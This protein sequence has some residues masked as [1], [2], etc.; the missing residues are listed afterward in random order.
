MRTGIRLY[1]PLPEELKA[2]QL[3]LHGGA[4]VRRELLPYGHHDITDDDVAAVVRA[5]RSEWLTTGPAIAEFETAIARAIGVDHA[6]AVNS[7]TAALHAAMFAIGIGPGDEVIVPPITFAA[8]ANAVVYQG[9]TP[10]FAD[11]DPET[12]LVD[13]AQAAAKITPRT[14]AIVS[15]TAR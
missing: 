4:P 2:R 7:G 6:V 1:R 10:V 13:P 3:A 5:L 8:T 14:R 15:R 12:L 9:G 11:V